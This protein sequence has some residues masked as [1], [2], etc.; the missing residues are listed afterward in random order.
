MAEKISFELQKPSSFSS[1]KGAYWSKIDPIPQ[2][3]QGL[4]FKSIAST[5][6]HAPHII[7]LPYTWL[8]PFN[9]KAWNEFKNQLPLGSGHIVVPNKESQGYVLSTLK[10]AMIY[11]PPF[12]YIPFAYIKNPSQVE[13]VYNHYPHHIKCI[14][15]QEEDRY[16]AVDLK[17]WEEIY[18]QLVIREDTSLFIAY[19]YP[20]RFLK[21]LQKTA[22]ELFQ[23]NLTIIV[24]QRL[25]EIMLESEQEELLDI[26][27]RRKRNRAFVVPFVVDLAFYPIPNLYTTIVI[28]ET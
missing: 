5:Y 28:I 16:A 10:R 18:S 8:R 3:N 21:F 9:I 1:E 7:S 23:A 15:I 14:S 26:L 22:Q 4:L 24:T 13:K 27:Q 19:P 2:F 11:R 25:Y 6:S 12:P 20:K 17:L